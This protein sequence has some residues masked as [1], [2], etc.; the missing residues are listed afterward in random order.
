[1][2]LEESVGSSFTL[3][4][5]SAGSPASNVTWM[6]DGEIIYI[7]DTFEVVQILQDG[8]MAVYNNFLKVYLEPSDV[9]G[10]YTCV[11]EN[12]VSEPD[13]QT[14]PIQGHSLTLCCMA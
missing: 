10:N 13:E 6:K 2:S 12:L 5:T 9:I 8:V 11:V 1:M 7:N 14:L 4:C 3:N